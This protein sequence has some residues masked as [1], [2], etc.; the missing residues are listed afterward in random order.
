MENGKTDRQGID[1]WWFIPLGGLHQ[2]VEWKTPP[3]LTPWA[4]KALYSFTACSVW[5]T[6]TSMP[7]FSRYSTV[8]GG[9]WRE[10]REM[11]KKGE[12]GPRDI[13]P[14]LRQL[15]FTESDSSG[16]FSV[17]RSVAT[18]AWGRELQKRS[19]RSWSHSGSE[20]V[21]ACGRVHSQYQGGKNRQQSRAR[22]VSYPRFSP[23][24]KKKEV[25][26]FDSALD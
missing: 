13:F 23:G 16:H 15:Y 14:V 7:C 10:G 8:D 26:H 21:R 24:E 20:C 12:R 22:R 2:Q 4:T 9:T 1:A 6:R 5:R 17:T 18:P 25:Q 11:N 3:T 19:L